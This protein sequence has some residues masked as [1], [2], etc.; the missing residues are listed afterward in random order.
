MFLSRFSFIS[1]SFTL[2]ALHIG[3][4]FFSVCFLM[5]A[6]SACLYKCTGRFIALPL[7]AAAGF[8]NYLSF[9]LSFLCD[10][11]GAVRQAIV[12]ADRSFL[13]LHPR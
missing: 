6:I 2:F 9:T 7:A 5:S 1:I 8:P 11:Q 13:F 10:G 3:S 4:V 12:Y